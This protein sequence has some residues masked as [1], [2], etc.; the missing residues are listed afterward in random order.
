MGYFRRVLGV[1]FRDKKHRSKIRK[2]RGVKPLPNREN[3]AMLVQPCVQNVPGK[4][5]E[6]STSGYS[7]HLRESDPEFAKGPGGVTT[8]PTLLGPILVWSQQNYLRLLLIVRY[9]GPS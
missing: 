4:N 5:G 1:T 7:L 6:I 3:S 2:P 8:S 9:F